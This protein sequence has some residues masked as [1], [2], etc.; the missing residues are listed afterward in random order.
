MSD[1][2]IFAQ[3]LTSES[4]PKG[5]KSLPRNITTARAKSARKP[6]VQPITLNAELAKPMGI[7]GGLTPGGK[8]NDKRTGYIG[9]RLH[10]ATV[11][12]DCVV[13]IASGDTYTLKRSRTHKPLTKSQEALVRTIA[14]NRL[15]R[16]HKITAG[17]L[18]AIGNID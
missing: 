2:D 5:S 4:L 16:H 9:A 6:K 15:E 17:D 18:E 11:T 13:T 3:W 7:V 14:A 12:S 8:G 1:A 10:D